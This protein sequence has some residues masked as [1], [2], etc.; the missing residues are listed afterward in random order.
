MKYFYIIAA[1]MLLACLLPMPYGYYTLVRVVAMAAFAIKAIDYYKTGKTELC[2][3]CAAVVILFQPLVPLSLGR[4][5]W[6][7][8]DVAAAVFLIYCAGLFKRR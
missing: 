7:I 8:V 2:V 1:A 3:G 4:L 5:I 6:N